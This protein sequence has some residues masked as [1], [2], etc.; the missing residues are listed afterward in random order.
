MLIMMHVTG[1][2]THFYFSLPPSSSLGWLVVLKIILF[3]IIKKVKVAFFLTTS[4]FWGEGGGGGGQILHRKNKSC[5][6]QYQRVIS[7]IKDLIFT[8]QNNKQQNKY[9]LYFF[10]CFLWTFLNFSAAFFRKWLVGHCIACAA[11]CSPKFFQPEW[12]Q[13]CYWSFLQFN[14]FLLLLYLS[15]IAL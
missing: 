8:L 7:S 3:V 14:V 6:V 13:L 9:S 10:A 1:G 2:V 11:R 12:T 15:L 5:Y 4:I